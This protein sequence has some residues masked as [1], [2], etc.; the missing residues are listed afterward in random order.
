M[1]C[2]AGAMLMVVLGVGIGV[3]FTILWAGRTR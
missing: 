2:A 3:L 1:L